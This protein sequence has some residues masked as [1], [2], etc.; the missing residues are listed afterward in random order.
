VNGGPRYADNIGDGRFLRPAFA[1]GCGFLPLFHPAA[2]F[3]THTMATL[4][5]LHLASNSEGPGV[6]LRKTPG[7]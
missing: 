7:S 6:R 4:K 3:P 1:G 2:I 5:E